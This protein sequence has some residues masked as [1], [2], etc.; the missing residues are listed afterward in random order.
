[1]LDKHRDK[2]ILLY[3]VIDLPYRR[4]EDIYGIHFSL[5]KSD[6]AECYIEKQMPLD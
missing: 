5:A 3:L 4:E 1:M 2:I 6:K